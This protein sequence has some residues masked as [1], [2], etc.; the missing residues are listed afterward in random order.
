MPQ[1]PDYVK[2]IANIRGNV[3]SIM[4]FEEKFGLKNTEK[5]VSMTKEQSISYTLV[6]ESDSFNVG[7]LV[8]EVPKTLSVSASKID[9]SFNIM[10]HSTLDES[11]IKGIV[12]VKNRMIILIDVLLMMSTGELKTKTKTN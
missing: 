3:I 6:I 8:N 12:K 10:Q 7:I 11:V 9:D 2:G 1:T 4:D 5:S